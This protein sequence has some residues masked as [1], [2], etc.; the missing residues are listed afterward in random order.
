MPSPQ[1]N[2]YRFVFVSTCV[3]VFSAYYFSFFPS[4]CMDG[5]RD[6]TRG[7]RDEFLQTRSNI[8]Y[9]K[10]KQFRDKTTVTVIWI[11]YF[12]QMI[13]IRW[14]I[15]EEKTKDRFSGFLFLLGFFFFSSSSSSYVCIS[16]TESSR[17]VLETA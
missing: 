13:K 15:Y 5:N 11:W 1:P 2:G 6:Y 8:D 7:T 3:C 10:K 17:R 4:C 16:S 9:R 12:Y 14:R